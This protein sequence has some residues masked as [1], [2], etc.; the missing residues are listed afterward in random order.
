MSAQ[1]RGP[2]TDERRRVTVLEEAEGPALETTDHEVAGE[3]EAIV[4]HADSW[5]VARGWLR[6]LG[7]FIAVAFAVIEVLLLFRF[8]FLLAGANAANGFVDFIYDVTGWM[9]E[10]FDNII[11]AE[12]VDGG[13]FD[14][15]TLIAIV[16]YAAVALLLTMF[17]WAASSAPSTSGER[18]VTT[19]SRH[20]MRSIRG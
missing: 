11:A 16:V 18:A 4:S 7:A 6:T 2:N 3:E 1:V 13:I 17:L 9:V 15:G 8:S 12:T 19:R 5:T 20:R 10:P 14:P